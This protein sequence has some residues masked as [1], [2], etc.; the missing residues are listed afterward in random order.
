MD[1]EWAEIE[2][3]SAEPLGVDVSPDALAYTIYTSGSTGRPKGVMNA[4]RAI[5]NRLHWLW[6]G[7]RLDGSEVMLQKTPFSFDIS[8]PE[9]FG[10]LTTGAR[11]VLAR[12]GGHRDPVYLSRVIESEGVTMLNF[13]PPMMQAFLEVGELERCGSLRRV[14]N[15]GEALPFALQQR[16]CAA[17]PHVELHN[18]YG[19]TEA[20]VEL[21]YWVCERD[22]ARGTVPIG[23]PVANTRVYVL[24]E[25]MEPVPPGVAGELYLGGV[26]VARGYLNRPALTAE[27]FVPDPFG[28]PGARL[29]RTGDRVKRAPDGVVEY[30]GRIDFQLK[31]RGFR[32]EPG[33]IEAALRALPGV[34]EAVVVAREDVPGSRRLVAY[35][36]GDGVEVE[37]LRAALGRRLPEYMVPAAFLVLPALPLLPNGKVD[38]KSLPAPE[39]PA[40]EAERYVAPRGGAEAALAA[41]WAEL[42]GVERVGAHDN[43]F[44]LGGDSILSIQV[45]SRARRAGLEITPRHLFEHPTVER[46]AAAAAGG[47]RVEAEQGI[48]TGALPLTPVQEWFFALHTADAHHWNLPV[49]VETRHPLDPALLARALEHLLAH[50][51]GLRTRFAP[52]AGGWTAEVAA[53]GEPAVLETIDLAGLPAEARGEA[54]AAHGARVQASLS[55]GGPLLKAA[56]FPAGGGAPGLLLLAAHHLVMD[57]VSRQV[58]LE[59]LRTAYGQLA[60]GQ[61]VSLPPKTTSFRAWAERLARHAREGGFDAELPFWTDPARAHAALLPVDVPE[62]ANTEASAGTVTLALTAEET[63]ALLAGVAGAYS[64]QV[65]DALLAALGRALN[66]WTGG[67]VALVEVEGHGREEIFADVDLS[68]T[69]GWFTTLSPVLLDLRGAPGEGEALMAVKEHLRALPGRGLGHG[70][71]LYGGSPGARAALA[72]LP[73]PQV[74]FNYLGQAG[75]SAEPGGPFGASSAS[76]GADRG[77]QAL[78]TH[79]LEVEGRIDGGRLH[80][81]WTHGG[82]HRRETAERLLAAMMSE[83]RAIATHCAAPDAGAYTPSDFPLAAVGQDLLD[84]LEEDLLEDDGLLDEADYVY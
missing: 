12:P 58:V 62:G 10:P 34:G 66:G 49:L 68:R 56:Y 23:H 71:L 22:G 31:I 42:L 20:A 61:A 70:A 1:E 84:L 37:E 83:L 3:E 81:S 73:R 39:A 75:A 14:V 72:A 69:V 17:L 74:L 29:Y 16:F 15:G 64:A 55:L 65:N 24:D 19:P 77:M 6:R 51:D 26:Q 50:H 53:P 57:N 82:L 30:L 5:V 63:S 18:L 25:A 7:F 80:V 2:R 36:T 44:A 67:E 28:R 33:E 41:I 76:A 78:R 47:K 45:V 27:K 40:A 9:F 4:H 60:A 11:L 48:V 54:V 43:F 46:L 8:I 59:D 21:M 38:R 35:L 32:I 79:L 13:V 52:G